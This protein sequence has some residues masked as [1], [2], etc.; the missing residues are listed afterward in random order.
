MRNGA[1][2]FRLELVA[3]DYFCCGEEGA[4]GAVA[5]LDFGCGYR[6]H[7]IRHPDGMDFIARLQHL[8]FQVEEDLG[9]AGTL[10]G[11]GEDGFIDDLQPQRGLHSFALRVG[12]AEAYAGFVAGLIDGGVGRGVDLEF[13]GGLYEDQAVVAHGARVS[14]EEVGA[15]IHGAGQI[16]RDGKSQ[17]RLTVGQVEIAGEHGLPVLH[18]VDVGRAALSRGEDF[19]EN[20]ITGSIDGAFGAEED[21][22]VTLAKFEGDGSGGSIALGV[23]GFYLEG[24]RPGGLSDWMRMTATPPGSVVAVWSALPAAWIFKVAAAGVPSG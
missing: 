21:L 13:V 24:D 14:T 20:A 19:E 18:D 4:G 15:E 9:E 23:G 3:A 2:E 11:E 8:L 7:D 12:D 10:L 6:L 22:I 16:G 17:F 5:L 1:A